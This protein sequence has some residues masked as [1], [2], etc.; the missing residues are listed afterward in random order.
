MTIPLQR[1][2][3]LLKAYLRPQWKQMSLLGSLL[4][5]SI[6]LQLLNPQILRGFIDAAARGEAMSMLVGA[7]VLFLVAGLLNQLLATAATSIGARVGWRA[8]NLLRSR[9]ADHVIRQDMSFHNDRTPGELIERI[10]GDVTALA[11]FF[12]QFVIR[13]LGALLL[14]V[15]V[16]VLLTIE[17]P[18]VGLV[19]LLYAI[20]AM[21]A[22]SRLKNIAIN[23]T[24]QEREASAVLYGFVEE[25]LSG[26]DDIRANGGGRYTIGRFGRALYNMLRKGRSAWMKRSTLWVSIIT[27]FTIGDVIALGMG[28]WLFGLG[29]ITL[30]TVYLFFQYTQ[31]MWGV[32]EQITHQ[33]QDLQK[34]G[35]SI[36]RVEELLKHRP[37]MLD[38]PGRAI[39][40]G[41]LRVEFDHVGFSYG[42]QGNVLHNVSFTLEPG[43]ILG[44]L[45]RT[46]SGKSTMTRL[47]FRLYDPTEGVIRLGGVD[48]REAT[49]DGLRK[50]VAMVTQ[51]VQ[52]FHS[53]VRNNI[54]FFDRSIPDSRIYEVVD[55]LDL[56][57][58]IEALPDGLDTVLATSGG[59]LSAG[60]AQLIAFMRVFL[61]DPGLVILDE[62][63]SRMDMATEAM[64]ERAMI[65][66][67]KNR[68][69]IIIAHR[70]P[71]VERADSIMILENG[72][73]RE[74]APRQVLVA[75]P[76]S[77][78]SELLRVHGTGGVAHEEARVTL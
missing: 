9:L 2:F 46:G 33:M 53:S 41:A 1:Y 25:R 66:L 35:A 51:E 69:A 15:G 8:T 58:W 22:L 6:G 38:G 28:I 52:L 29:A 65:R 73:I 68:T 4:L 34:A 14:I 30:G 19:E 57:P 11:N 27:L 18:R 37:N 56:R 5:G 67:M 74:H 16:L 13:I 32:V 64:L 54:T 61:R 55:E 12:S 42:S 60:E 3:D 40:P 7:G 77:R 20:G 44:L 45:G 76:T 75:D 10:D 78:F 63:S 47:L 21:L 43:E 49:I 70:L 26:I 23:A 59:G 39:P 17:D 71:T 62:P 36:A 48:L 31:M 72:A 24:E 50:R